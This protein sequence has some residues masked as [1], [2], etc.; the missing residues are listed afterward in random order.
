MIVHT[1]PPGASYIPGS[2]RLDA[3]T[4]PDPLLGAKGQLYWVI[5]LRQSGVLTYRVT[6]T[7]KLAELAAPALIARYGQGQS[8][9]LS[10]TYDAA[11]L[12]SARPVV[13]AAAAPGE[14]AGS[15]K[16]PVD[17]TVFRLR[18]RI[19]VTVQ[20]PLGTALTPTLNGAPLGDEQIGSR[21]ADTASNTQRLTY[22]GAALKPGANVLELG[23]DRVTVYFASVTTRVDIKPLQLVADGTTPIRLQL[24]AFD[25]SG[26][27]TS[28][29]TLTLKSNLEPL[30]P[31]AA[32]GD[33]GYQVR[34]TDGVG[35][36]VLATAGRAQPP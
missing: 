27:L 14:N 12:S 30:D 24:R 23:H 36:L 7:G 32:P 6:Y 29:P 33:A 17:G 11:D 31:D 13:V 19:S 8:E 35:E 1:L 3:Q 25:A 18:D 4:L 28:L 15:I 22:V 34:L 20:G 16:L 26:I 5:P 21:T 10:G 2:A 9:V